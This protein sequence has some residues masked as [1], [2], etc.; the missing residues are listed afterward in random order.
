M[1][2]LIPTP[3]TDKNGHT[4]VRHIKADTSTTVSKKLLSVPQLAQAAPA[5]LTNEE[6]SSLIDPQALIPKGLSTYLD[7][8]RHDNPKTL[9]LIGELLTTGNKTGRKLAARK[10]TSMLNEIANSYTANPAKWSRRLS[11]NFG[12]PMIESE[13]AKNWAIGNV[14]EE[15]GI[16]MSSDRDYHNL[17]GPVSNTHF[18]QQSGTTNSASMTTAYWRGTIAFNQTAIGWKEGDKKKIKAFISWAGD[19]ENLQTIIDL[20]SERNTLDVH[21]LTGVLEEQDSSSPV[22]DGVL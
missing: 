18:L 22:R 5:G 14:A 4:V 15:L 11:R 1:S 16:G 20:A 3:R 9:P 6:I 17:H 2:N 8:L 13:I 19:Q 10:F 21:T 12:S 7:L